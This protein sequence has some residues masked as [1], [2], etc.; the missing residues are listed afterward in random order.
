MIQA[1]HRKGGLNTTTRIDLTLE[2]TAEMIR[3]AQESNKKGAG[4][5]SGHP[6]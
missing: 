3:E 6:F 5:A 1:N 4:G 2:I